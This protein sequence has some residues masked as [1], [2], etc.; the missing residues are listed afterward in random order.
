M[1]RRKLKHKK[2]AASAPGVSG[3]SVRSTALPT[4]RF[5]RLEAQ[6][7]TLKKTQLRRRL[8]KQYHETLDK[9]GNTQ[10][11]V[12]RLDKIAPVPVKRVL[13]PVV[14]PSRLDDDLEY[15]ERKFP[16]AA[17]N[18]RKLNETTS[19]AEE[20]QERA[21]AMIKLINKVNNDVAKAEHNRD[22]K[23]R[24][25]EN[26]IFQDDIM[27]KRAERGKLINKQK[28]RLST[29][30]IQIKN[31]SLYTK[32]LNR[33][34]QRL[35]NEQVVFGRTMEAYMK[36]LQAQKDETEEVEELAR[37]IAY[38]HKVTRRKISL[39]HEDL[40]DEEKRMESK[41]KELRQIARARTSLDE[42][43]EHIK[44]E[45]QRREQE[46]EKVKSSSEMLSRWK[47][48]ASSIKMH[49]IEDQMDDLMDKFRRIELVTGLNTARQIIHRFFHQDEYCRE[50]EQKTLFLKGQI[51]K[52]HARAR[53]LRSTHD[54]EKYFGKSQQ[55]S[56]QSQI[57]VERFAD[58]LSK[59]HNHNQEI[60]EENHKYAEYVL[61]AVQSLRHMLDT[62]KSANI[63]HAVQHAPDNAPKKRHLK[64]GEKM[65]A[66]AHEVESA[67]ENLQGS[68]A[69]IFKTI[70]PHLKDGLIHVARFEV[71]EKLSS[72]K[73]VFSNPDATMEDQREVHS[74]IMNNVVENT[75]NVRVNVSENIDR[76]V[77]PNLLINKS[78]DLEMPHE[79]QITIDKAKKGDSKT[80]KPKVKS[81]VMQKQEEAAKLAASRANRQHE[82]ML[83]RKS[84]KAGI[85]VEKMRAIYEVIPQQHKAEVLDRRSLK[86][87][88]LQCVRKARKHEK[89]WNDNCDEKNERSPKSRSR[90][91]SPS[92]KSLSRE[93]SSSPSKSLHC[94]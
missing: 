27:H 33:M 54:N 22:D 79:A 65:T 70:F 37:R 16:R 74:Q 93:S 83:K 5:K 17:R 68:V 75:N 50:M 20:L 3:N 36:A 44:Q 42:E 30:E 66:T 24:A 87:S 9:D 38:L 49:S 69:I 64:V 67:M 85:D 55:S 13:A 62:V 6:V 76:P 53:K 48:N 47:K 91:S 26:L 71:S 4:S 80:R 31:S 39:T 11:T 52:A 29:T 40:V 59:L 46:L 60:K 51:T 94:T 41:L 35:N 61:S 45:K 72:I 7:R 10:L 28:T 77:P 43:F 57:E 89:K 23:K 25:L 58:K 92:H 56:R 88:S 18:R 1:S 2:R 12:V 19:M 14:M 8:G 81:K 21:V 90:G 34:L 73:S 63:P 86:Y 84:V 82:A 32:T 15:V 78:R